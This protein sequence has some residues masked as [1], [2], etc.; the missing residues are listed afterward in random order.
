MTAKTV[1][2]RPQG[3][4]PMALVHLATSLL[5]VPLVPTTSAWASEREGC[6]WKASSGVRRFLGKGQQL[7]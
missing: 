6:Y 7:L 4:R 1:L 3:Q 2:L 5:V